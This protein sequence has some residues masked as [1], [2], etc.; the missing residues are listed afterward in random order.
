MYI[1]YLTILA[2][3]DFSL[4]RSSV[5]FQPD[6]SRVCYQQPIVDDDIPEPIEFLNVTIVGNPDIMIGNPGITQINIL[7]DDGS[8]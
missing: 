5:T 3:S 2:P 4:L 6:Q 8:E 7:D 1:I